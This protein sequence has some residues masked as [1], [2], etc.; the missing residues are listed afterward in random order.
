MLA[1]L[2]LPLFLLYSD[3]YYFSKPKIL[4]FMKTFLEKTNSKQ[5]PNKFQTN[6]KQIPNKF[7]TNS[8]QIPNKFQTNSKQI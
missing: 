5:I 3:K 7:Q 8:K 2:K 4:M 1:S 6:S